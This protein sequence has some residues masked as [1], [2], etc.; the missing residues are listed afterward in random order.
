MNRKET[1]IAAI[2][3]NAILL[4]VLFATSLRSK[5][6]TNDSSLVQTAS[7]QTIPVKVHPKIIPIV[8]EDILKEFVPGI[9]K[10][11]TANQEKGVTSSTHSLTKEEA[12]GMTSIPST[13]AEESVRKLAEKEKKE[14]FVN[15]VVKKGDFLER[16][17]KANRTT[18]T[19]IMRVNNLTST[20][21]QIGQ[22]LKVPLVDDVNS[23]E[24]QAA[25]FIDS[26]E[27]YLI[28]EGDS[29]WAIAMRHR[30]KLEDLLRL[31]DLDEQRARTLKPGD[32]LRIR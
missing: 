9:S 14:H 19:V 24:S 1:M 28:K 30:M 7:E 31:N 16:I 20:Q 15:V 11:E 21:L 6:A 25:T 27:Y 26:V 3:V 13:N 22:I 2:A 32:R 12:Y 29:P 5:N 18:V 10:K 23:T 17:A 4:V 8:E